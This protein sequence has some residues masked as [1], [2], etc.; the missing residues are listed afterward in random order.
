M[1]KFGV[2][3]QVTKQLSGARSLAVVESGADVE[4]R[5]TILEIMLPGC[6]GRAELVGLLAG[7]LVASGK[8]GREFVEWKV[9]R[10]R[11]A[12]AQRNQAGCA[13]VFCG[14]FQAIALSASRLLGEAICNMLLDSWETNTLLK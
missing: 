1:D 9:L 14:L 6:D 7:E 10:R 4:E 12:A 11:E 8:L 13:Q 2:L 5:G 3:D